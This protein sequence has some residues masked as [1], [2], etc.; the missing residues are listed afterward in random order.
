MKKSSVLIVLVLLIIGIMI[1][2]NVFADGYYSAFI[3]Y[4]FFVEDQ[5]EN[6][7]G[8]L[9]FKLHDINNNI[10]YDSYY[11][12]DTGAYSFVA[13]N[14]DMSFVEDDFLPDGL[15]DEIKNNFDFNNIYYNH[16]GIYSHY[17]VPVINIP[18]VLEE[19]D[20]VGSS[21]PI[22]KIVFAEVPLR[23]NGFQLYLMNNTC[24]FLDSNLWDVNETNFKQTPYFNL[25]NYS[26]INYFDYSDEL[27][28]RYFSADISSREIHND[29][30]LNK[31]YPNNNSKIDIPIT[32][33]E[34]SGSGFVEGTSS[35]V[36][37]PKAV[38]L[39]SSEDN[40]QENV[41]KD[42]CDCLPVFVQQRQNSIVDVITNP[43]TWTN[44]VMVLIISII[45]IIGI[46]IY[47][48]SNKKKEIM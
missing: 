4:R 44:G 7:I 32:S 46:V 18:L 12:K 17:D 27:I 11:D 9:K 39:R 41:M 28:D 24:R 3:D 35:T 37:S 47:E 19:V 48:V 13:Y 14:V 29:N 20:H 6:N 40:I 2:T 30:Y 5:D 8:N 33:N 21:E 26:R 23:R 10:S 38:Q 1:P 31:R 45:I 15:M 42:Y 34:I 16:Y 43:K 22:K 25:I 36:Y